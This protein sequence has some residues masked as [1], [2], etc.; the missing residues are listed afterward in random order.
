MTN[1]FTL[2]RL[3]PMCDRDKDVEILWGSRSRPYH[4]TCASGC[5]R[6][7]LVDQ[8]TADRA[9][10]HRG[11][12]RLGVDGGGIRIDMQLGCVIGRPGRDGL[13]R[14]VR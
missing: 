6:F 3:L 2:L 12:V 1:A 14:R 8:A 11:A 13:G 7:V 5:C 4:L 9:A 10:S